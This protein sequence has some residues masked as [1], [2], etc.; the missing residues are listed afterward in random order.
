MLETATAL[1]FQTVELRYVDRAVMVSGGEELG[2]KKGDILS[3][4][5]TYLEKYNLFGKEYYLI[6]KRRI[7]G[8]W[9]VQ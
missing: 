3:F 7:Q 1:P 8:K 9:H 4:D 5:P 2:F 6:K